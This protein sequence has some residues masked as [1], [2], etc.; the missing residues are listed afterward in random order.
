M[1]MPDSPPRRPRTILFV[2]GAAAIAALLFACYAAT[3]RS[4]AGFA[5]AIDTCEGVFCD[6]VRFYYPMGG[7]IFHAAL[8]VP[9]FLYSPFVAILLAMFPPLGLETSLTL[10][11]ALQLLC[12]VLYVLLIRRLVP[13]GLA[14]QL[15]AAGLVLSSFPVLHNFD[16]GQVGVF[17]VVAILGGLL[18]YRSGHRAA[19]AAALALAA[20]FKFFPL[21]FLAPFAARRDGRFLALAVGACGALLF[22]V[23]GLALGFGATLRFYG[24]LLDSCRD[25]GWVAGN[26]NSQHFPHVVL[27]L[28]GA[29]GHDAA[30]WLPLL[31]GISYGI[32]AGNAGLLLLVVRRGLPHAEL[33]SFQLLFL[34][35]PFVL[36]TSWPADLAY[37]PFAQV[38]LAWWLL[39][40][41]AG[42]SRGLAAEAQARE[43]GAA[44]PGIRSRRTGMLVLL[45]ASVVAS[46]IFFF[47]LVG[48][49]FLYGAL[50]CLFWANLFLLAACHV[51]LLPR[52]LR[53][54]PPGGRAGR[55]GHP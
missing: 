11:G 3:W 32:A 53:P 9:G 43:E 6:F 18:L 55:G 28:A 51:E 31:R 7:A 52:A 35:V 17:A 19:A 26:Y 38:F 27:R 25:M 44:D 5:S 41:R 50:G 20:S 40:G 14:I 39:E 2:A 8:P 33:W 12:V 34:T 46:N 23:P 45:L 42:R 15:L 49:R 16:W 13:A 10:W 48:D 37:L 30:A 4:Y 21:I 29:T 22:L 24:A 54:V 1:S 47:N 36:G